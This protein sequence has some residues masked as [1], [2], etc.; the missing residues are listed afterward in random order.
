MPSEKQDLNCEMSER[1]TRQ[2]LKAAQRRGGVKGVFVRRGSSAQMVQSKRVDVPRRQSL[3]MCSMESNTS[4]QLFLIPTSFDALNA[5]LHT[6]RKEASHE[7][8]FWFHTGHGF[9]QSNS[10]DFA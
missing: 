8:L 10:R 9:L 7:I 1:T 4:I 5:G 3:A 2:G 6:K